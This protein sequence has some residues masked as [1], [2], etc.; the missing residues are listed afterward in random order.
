MSLI[1]QIPAMGDEEVANLLI[2]AR[3]LAERGNEAQQA[4]AAQLLPALE[5]EAETRKAA[6]TERAAAK[7]AA[8][9]KLTKTVAA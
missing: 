1:E 3:R 6:R 5:V 9:R 2:N 8:T 7:R 4:A